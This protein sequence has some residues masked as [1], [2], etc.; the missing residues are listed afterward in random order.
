[1]TKDVRRA[2]LIAR[3]MFAD[4]G[5]TATTTVAPGD[6]A[7]SGFFGGKSGKSGQSTVAKPAD[8]LPLQEP[9]PATTVNYQNLMPPGMGMITPASA[10]GGGLP[11]VPGF[12]AGPS[13]FGSLV[14][15]QA[16]LTAP[17]SGVTGAPNLGAPTPSV[18]ASGG[19]NPS[20]SQ[21][22]FNYAPAAAVPK[23]IEP[24]TNPFAP[25]ATTAAD[26]AAKNVYEPIEGSGTTS[27]SDGPGDSGDATGFASGGHVG[28]GYAD[29][30]GMH[31]RDFAPIGHSSIPEGSQTYSGES[32]AGENA[33]SHSQIGSQAGGLPIGGGVP[34]SQ[35]SLHPSHQAPLEGLPQRV[36][37]PLT[38]E[39]VEAGPNH[40]IR[41]VAEKYMR[42]MGLEYS[43]PKKYAKVD[44][45]RAQRIAHEYERMADDPAHPLVKASYEAMINE[46][47]AQYQ[48]AKKHGFVA[49]FWDPEKERDPYEASPRLAIEDINKNNHM[50]VFPTYFGYGS[51][52]IPEEER[53]KNPL[54]ADSGERWN[55]YPVTVNDVFRAVHDYYGHAKEGVGFRH[56]GEENAWR[57]HASMYS[58]LARLA[59]TSETRGQ[60]SWLNFGPH[61]EHNKKA[62]TEDTVFADQKIGVMAPWTAHEGAEDFMSP[63]DIL[64][65][66]HAYKGH[67]YA[68][69]GRL[70]QDEYPTHYMP[71]VG[72]QMMG[73]GG[74]PGE[75][76]MI[77]KAMA[78]AG[79]QAQGP[80][81]R[82]VRV[83]KKTTSTQTPIQK[84]WRFANI[85]EARVSPKPGVE[86][87]QIIPNEDNSNRIAAVS[88]AALGIL[89]H[90]NTK[91]FI[92]EN[93]GI[94]NYEVTPT[95]GT[96]N[97]DPEPSFAIHGK[98][99]TSDH[100]KTL[101]HL[102]G[103]GMWQDAA[104]HMSR[105]KSTKTGTPSILIGNGQKLS[106]DD[107][108]KIMS[109][110]KE[111]GF[112]LSI[113]KDKKGAIFSHF[114]ESNDLP[115]FTETVKKIAQSAGMP[116]LLSVRSKG[117]LVNAEQYLDGLFRG[118]GPQDGDRARPSR[119]PDLFR[120]IVDHILAP[121]T[122][123]ASAQG[124]RFSAEKF[125]DHHK[126][127]EEEKEILVKALN[128]TRKMPGGFSRSTIANPV[129]YEYPGIYG[130][131]RIMAEEAASRVAPESP[132]LKRLFGV[133]RADLYQMGANRVGNMEPQIAMNPNAKGSPAAR[134]IMT[135]ENEQRLIDILHEAGKHQALR[136]GMDAW[137]VMDPVYQRMEKILG[138]T[139]ARRRY[140]ELNSIVSMASPGSEVTTEINR[141]LA[142]HYLHRQGRFSDFVNY[143]GIP[144]EKRGSDFPADIAPVMGH[145]YH[146]T[147]QA[148]PMQQ[149]ITTGTMSG[150]KSPKV[151]LYAQSSGVPETG[152]QTKLPV[153]DAH[154]TRAVGLSDARKGIDPGV[155]SSMSEY[156]DIGP[157]F[158]KK[159]AAPLG[160][161][162][163]PAQARLW[164]AA[165][166]STGVDTAIGSPK[167]E[168]LANHIMQ[169]AQ[170]H[171]ISPEDARDRV[172]QGEIYSKGG[173]VN[174]DV[175]ST[176]KPTQTPDAILRALALSRSITKGT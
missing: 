33:A 147:S 30:G 125:A 135:P 89:N 55:G 100:A 8:K 51:K 169:V 88:S 164:G 161:Q 69:G 60:N 59:M 157:W 127:S 104:V 129:G 27:E 105:N 42:D 150:M 6:S 167:I 74:D 7:F 45:E 118:V 47:M 101:A 29:G 24:T 95:Y 153:P 90:P 144:V 37:I 84:V 138:P 12:M 92:Q 123:A 111:Q 41:A 56:D 67:K 103:F 54:L 19:F 148:G 72:R 66:E 11:N 151:P 145:A 14:P 139:E 163:V 93:F 57:S 99:I 83:A 18:G 130:N 131:P 116:Y 78:I 132:A 80:V 98:D 52:E 77:Q 117:E 109:R 44:P 31:S 75:D 68:R 38:G 175:A 25:S 174:F 154:F 155:S 91:K 149:Y 160:I 176:R 115:E 140:S 48:A 62:R 22:T 53:A 142:A 133:T 73:D 39:F 143:A 119:S 106:S 15:A 1:M 28:D 107:V 82:A 166:G 156:Q 34:G 58:P 43:P 141:G 21:A 50:Y 49:E 168:M 128:P 9:L 114:G 134:S 152:F 94:P 40:H 20:L 171:G 137:Y 96:W 172:L 97:T 110:A 46:T 3:R 162:A 79:Q 108:N 61:G 124:Y 85:P 112:D 2:L 23:L 36:K 26:A 158:S 126:L 5:D 87:G 173:S 4:G 159:V 71:H 120:G 63:E 32:Y 13:G 113:T 65:I 165:S 10:P 121:Y 122:K 102:L 16:S 17:F 76:P 35:G 146:K 70:L 170:R 81:S 86:F 136:H 64:K